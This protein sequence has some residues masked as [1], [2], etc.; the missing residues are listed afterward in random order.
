MLGL[1]QDSDKPHSPLFTE[2][3]CK[4][5]TE[6]PERDT[7]PRAISQLALSRFKV[8]MSQVQPPL[9]RG[10]LGWSWQK[11]PRDSFIQLFFRQ[12]VPM[13]RELVCIAGAGGIILILRAGLTGC[14]EELHEFSETVGNLNR[15]LVP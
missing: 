9:Y 10:L 6:V 14:V 2:C 5:F 3:V 11:K 1:L 13:V 8:S 12:Q 15:G 4:V 7:G